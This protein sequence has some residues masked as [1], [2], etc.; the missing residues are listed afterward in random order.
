MTKDLLIR[1]RLTA[2]QVVAQAGL[3]WPQVDK[4]LLVGGSTHMPATG[5]ML[6]ELY[7]QEPER[8]LAVSE[9]VARGAAL[10]AG[11]RPSQGDSMRESNSSAVS[12]LDDVVEISVNAHSLGV[13]VR[14]GNER[15]NHKLVPKNTQLPASAEQVYYTV[16]DNQTRVRVRIL[17]GEAHQAAACIPVGEC[18]ID[19]LPGNLP[20]S[21]PVRVRCG[22]TANGR[23]EVTAT[24]L[25]SGRAATAAI[26]RPGGLTED[27]L[28]HETAWV[29]NLRIQ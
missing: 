25:T 14:Q 11:I 8:S 20:K 29:R 4:V 2:Q 21:S 27:E 1:T 23:I 17:Q 6:A 9:V 15:M 22:V 18:W 5:R 24:D 13:E 26:H 7:G 19:G 16:T 10:H 3:T 12:T 28:N